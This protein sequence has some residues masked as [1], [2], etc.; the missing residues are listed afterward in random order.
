MNTFFKE[1]IWMAASGL[2]S[3]SF[4]QYEQKEEY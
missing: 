4:V 3:Y 1:R 2:P